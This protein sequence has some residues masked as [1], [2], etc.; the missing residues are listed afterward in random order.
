MSSS[1]DKRRK[2]INLILTGVAWY[3]I[4][5]DLT[6]INAKK[7]KKYRDNP[8][9]HRACSINGRIQFVLVASNEVLRRAPSTFAPVAD[10]ISKFT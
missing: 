8:S 9:V 5:E 3:S 6:S 2:L 1:S 7:L 10:V 4:A